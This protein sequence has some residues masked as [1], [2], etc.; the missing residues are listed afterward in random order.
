MGMARTVEVGV[1]L[2]ATDDVSRILNIVQR[3]LKK[4]EKSL[5]DTGKGSNR[6]AERFKRLMKLATSMGKGLNTMGKAA[7]RAFYMYEMGARAARL[8][9]QLMVK[10]LMDATKAA[11]DFERGIWQIMLRSLLSSLV[12][13]PWIRHG[14]FTLLYLPVPL[15]RKKRTRFCAFL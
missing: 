15:A 5:E 13:C 1:I 10:P 4:L 6:L 12:R 2:S 7:Q 14:L 3:R 9:F 8:A 11:M